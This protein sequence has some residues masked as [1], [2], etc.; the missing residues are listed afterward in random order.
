MRSV[1]KLI[2][3][4]NKIFVFSKINQEHRHDRS[5]SLLVASPFPKPIDSGTATSDIFLNVMTPIS[6]NN[7]QDEEEEKSR[8][9]ENCC[10]SRYKT[11]QKLISRFVDSKYFDRI[12]FAAILI[13]TL[14]MALEYHGQPQLLTDILEYSNYVFILLFTIEILFRIITHGCLKYV[15]SSFN[16]FDAVIV[17]ISLIELFGE[18]NSGLSV[19]R[20][21]RLLRELK[22][23]RC[24]PTL[25]R[26]L[27]S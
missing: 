11:I 12:I 19:L 20:A 2:F 26:Y 10:C 3:I 24:M 1:P 6:E 15:Q 27:V 21:F 14:L 18:K 8:R 16:L 13:N 5:Q 9:S 22:F 23:V 25:R 7:N 17:L 4:Q